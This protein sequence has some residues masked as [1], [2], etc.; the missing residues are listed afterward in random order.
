MKTKYLVT[1]WFIL[2]HISMY[3]QI[4]FQTTFGDANYQSGLAVKQCFDGGYILTGYSA[5]D[6]GLLI[7]TNKQG[8][9]LWTRT[10]GSKICGFDVIQTPDSNFVICGFQNIWTPYM[11]L[12]KVD[13]HGNTLW[14]SFPTQSWGQAMQQTFEGNFIIAGVKLILTD[15]LGSGLWGKNLEFQAM[16]VIQAA[17]SNYVVAGCG[18]ESNEGI[19]YLEKRD[20][21]GSLIWRK[22]FEGS[23]FNISN[24]ILAQTNTGGYILV[25]RSLQS[26][27]L[28]IIKTDANGDLI[29]TEEIEGYTGT[30]ILPT[31]DGGLVVGGYSN[32]VHSQMIILKIDSNATLQWINHFG[33]ADDNEANSIQQTF[34]GGFILTGKTT[35]SATGNTDVYLVKTDSLGNILSTGFSDP[36]ET[37][38]LII[39]PNP[40]HTS[41]TIEF[42]TQLENADIILYNLY[43]QVV[44]SMHNIFSQQVEFN[45]EG[46]PSGIY[47][48]NIIKNQNVIAT[49]KIIITD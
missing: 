31:R 24:N 21:V 44:K 47:F 48:I 4:T 42:N 13:A 40:F 36:A 35:S 41:T 49:E 45:R 8:E 18:Y 25:G 22:T 10:F 6:S 7:R 3:A 27:Q 33:F 15:S 11:H 5:P 26:G 12:I 39:Y 1:V 9:L 37:T 28:L 19:M 29:W 14:T 2:I 23:Y 34:D 32:A 38:N 17:D 20:T 43:G 30:S 46:L 16:Y